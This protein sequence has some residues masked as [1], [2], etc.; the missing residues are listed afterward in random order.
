M[1]LGL[2]VAYSLSR[3]VASARSPRPATGPE[4]LLAAERR[5]GLAWEAPAQ[6]RWSRAPTC[7]GR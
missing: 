1:V 4:E 2:W 3:L 7:S 6:P 5:L